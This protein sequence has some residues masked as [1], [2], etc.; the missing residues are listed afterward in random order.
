MYSHWIDSAE[1]Y[2]SNILLD[3][4][5]T[6]DGLIWFYS[7]GIYNSFK[8]V[9]AAYLNT[10]KDLYVYNDKVY[11]TWDF[12]WD[13]QD[14]ANPSDPS[15]RD[16]SIDISNVQNPSKLHKIVS[17]VFFDSQQIL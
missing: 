14:E 4:M 11:D 16:S 1:D 12:Y 3:T 6:K 15:Y 2:E 13:I 5:D 7:N 8:S 10:Y 17:D 9:Q